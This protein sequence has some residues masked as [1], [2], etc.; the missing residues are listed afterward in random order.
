VLLFLRP[1]NTFI[2]AMIALAVVLYVLPIHAGDR[3]R[4]VLAQYLAA[5][6]RYVAALVE[7]WLG[8][9]PAS[10]VDSAK[11]QLEDS[12]QMMAQG[13]PALAFDYNP[14]TQERSPLSS[15][16]T[17]IQTMHN[18]VTHFAESISTE[19][20]MITP[21]NPAVVQGLQSRFHL[22]VQGLQARLSRQ[23]LPAHPPAP[24]QAPRP[25]EAMT[26]AGGEARPS[27][28]RQALGFFGQLNHAV[29]MLSST[30]DESQ[31]I[32]SGALLAHRA[33]AG[34]EKHEPPH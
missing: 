26:Q 34:K 27:E 31:R 3:F 10:P 22:N 13:F 5:L 15:Q 20:G 4:L 25:G 14:V 29:T 12:Y 19:D 24:A 32:G 8:K 30:L 33:G 7:L 9:T 18:D 16:T 2:G 23:P 21:I 1:F 28:W 11:L 17:I 6:D